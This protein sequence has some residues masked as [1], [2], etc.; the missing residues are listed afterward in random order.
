MTIP[1]TFLALTLWQQPSPPVFEAD[2]NLVLIDAQVLDKE[3][4]QPISGL[5]RADFVVLDKGVPSDIVAFDDLRAPLNI[6]LLLDVSGGFTNEG[7]QFCTA[8]LLELREPDDRVALI[9]F[10][11][12][13]AKWTTGFTDDDGELEHAQKQ[14]FLVDRNNSR[15]RVS[16]SKL[17]D[18]IHSGTDMF[19]GTP[20]K[21]R[22]PVILVI[23]HNREKRSSNNQQDV[24]DKLLGASVRLE[25]ITIPQEKTA[26]RLWSRGDFIGMPRKPPAP[27]QPS[28]PEF[29]EDLHSVE[30]IVEAT[31]GQTVHLNYE[32]ASRVPRGTPV[33]REW[34]V[35]LLI[36]ILD[37]RIMKRLRNQYTLGIRGQEAAGESQFRRL[38]VQLS[39]AARRRYPHAVIYARLGYF[40]PPSAPAPKS[41][42]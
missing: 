39:E 34:K 31:G 8:A 20:K 36:D 26:I 7:V 22:R 30:P 16:N 19:A 37:E 3:T 5:T 28:P 42:K 12:G 41:S 13:K 11:D 35:P 21:M 29:L 15:R 33:P 9:S 23:T 17:L 25:A 4:R 6:L 1:A 24:I 27:S 32:N 10:S 40:T 38:D 2:T 18:A 14:I